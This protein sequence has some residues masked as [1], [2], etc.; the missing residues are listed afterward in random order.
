MLQKQM[1][2]IV[3]LKQIIKPLIVIG[4]SIYGGMYVDKYYLQLDNNEDVQVRSKE[5]DSYQVGDRYPK[6]KK[7]KEET[8]PKQ[9]NK[10]KTYGKTIH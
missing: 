1:E 4:K 10:K 6:K 3:Q 2:T 8:K 7:I 5:W 9:R